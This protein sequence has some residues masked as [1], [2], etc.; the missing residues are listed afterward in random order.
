MQVGVPL[1]PAANRRAGGIFLCIIKVCI[2]LIL[3]GLPSKVLWD[4]LD[5]WEVA[6]TQADT[7]S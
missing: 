5:K 7:F 1:T 6:E 4:I 3:D 2:S